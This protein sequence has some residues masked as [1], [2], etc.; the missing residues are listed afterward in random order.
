MSCYVDELTLYIGDKRGCKLTADSIDELH[1]FAK[2]LGLT[3]DDFAACPIYPDTPTMSKYNWVGKKKIGH[4][5]FY[6]ITEDVRKK[7]L[8]QGAIPVT[9]GNEPWRAKVEKKWQELYDMKSEADRLE[10]IRKNP[11]LKKQL[12]VN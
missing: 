9:L 8:K 5:E 11:R 12:G 1:F 10:L 2:K 7:A 3:K 4:R 6:A